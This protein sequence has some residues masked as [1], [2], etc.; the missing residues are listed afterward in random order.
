MKILAIDCSTRAMGYSVDI[1]GED[2]PR[3]GLILLP[4]MKTLG[5]LYAAVRNTL[6]DLADQ[7]RPDVLVWARPMFRDAQSAAQA[8]LGVAAIADLVA[9]DEGMRAFNV[10]ESS[11]R[12]DVLG[13]GGF[14]ERD[15]KGKIVPGSGTKGAKAAALAWCARQGFDVENHDVADAV[16]LH[17][18]AKR[19][20][21]A[22]AG[23]PALPY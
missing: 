10:V 3:H 22:R 19:Q 13:R 14:S 7:F 23:R 9:H 11:A 15:A 17:A 1:S 6:C 16:V 5:P 21:A 18:H 8:L 2:M 4:G 20:L 12:K